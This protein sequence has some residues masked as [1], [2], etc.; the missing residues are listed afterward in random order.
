MHGT[1]ECSQ[2]KRTPHKLKPKEEW[3]IT[4]NTY[5][6]IIDIELWEKVQICVNSRKRVTRTGELQLFAGFVKCEDCGSALSYAFSQNIPQYTCGRYRRYGKEGC[7]AH[8][9]RKDM[10]VQ[11]VL[12]DIRKHAQLAHEDEE[13]LAKQ[14]VSLN[15]EKE[16]R[17]IQALYTELN[18]AKARYS[19][20][21]RIIKR[22]F[23]QSA[24]GAITDNRFQKLSVE[25][26]AEQAEL[27]KR[28]AEIQDELDTAQQNSR[29]SSAWLELIR[30]YSNLQE[31]DRIV[32][33]ELID[34]IT[35]GEARVVD[36][37][38]VIDVTIYN[39][40][41]GVVGQ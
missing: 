23:E 31:L 20:L 32:L 18:T 13:G 17:H 36:G 4:P 12:D 29:D 37:E 19:D 7:S 27:E 21:D 9:I 5:E 3:L 34:K 35:V 30:D 28:I 22:L 38:K 15:D 26:E 25:Y 39:R 40:F 33:S 8:Y 16:E 14:L 41:V 1:Y 6:P 24:M 10:L 2:F 11:V